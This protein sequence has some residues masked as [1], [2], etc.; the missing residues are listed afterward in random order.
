[1]YSLKTFAQ[2]CNHDSAQQQ[3]EDNDDRQAAENNPYPVGIEIANG[4]TS[5]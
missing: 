1:L 5:P 3:A 2:K 4:L